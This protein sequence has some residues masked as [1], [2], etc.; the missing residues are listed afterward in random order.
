MSKLTPEIKALLINI[1]W[2]LTK[3][4]SIEYQFAIKHNHLDS[5]KIKQLINDFQAHFE[6]LCK[7]VEQ[8]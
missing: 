3:L 1:A 8:S 5:D 7:A 4:S 6:A 2:D